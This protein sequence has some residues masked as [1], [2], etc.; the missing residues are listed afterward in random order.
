M[1]M[2]GGGALYVEQPLQAVKIAATRNK[3]K[4]QS[5]G[6]MMGEM[7]SP[8]FINVMGFI[9]S[10]RSDKGMCERPGTYR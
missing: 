4:I 7:I 10:K 5:L 1:T 6:F 2:V 9:W 8:G 3:A